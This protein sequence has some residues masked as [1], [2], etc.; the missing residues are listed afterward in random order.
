MAD[1]SLAASVSTREQ[2]E[3]DQGDDRLQMGARIRFR[4][5]FA[6]PGQ[7]IR[8]GLGFILEAMR[9]HVPES[10]EALQH[11]DQIGLR[12]IQADESSDFS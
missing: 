5:M 10:V 2:L 9:D 7:M 8:D 6:F 12:V 1:H 3:Q 11:P 4:E